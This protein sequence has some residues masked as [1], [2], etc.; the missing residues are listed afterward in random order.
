MVDKFDVSSQFSS[1]AFGVV[2]LISSAA[3]GIIAHMKV[4]SMNRLII[5]P[6]LLAVVA[7]AVIP[8][9]NNVFLYIAL[10]AVATTAGY[11][12]GAG[13]TVLENNEVDAARATALSFMGSVRSLF[14]I[15]GPLIFGGIIDSIDFTNM[16]YLSSVACAASLVI[17]AF[18]IFFSKKEKKD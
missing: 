13:I 17:L 6:T 12:R 8:S 11:F 7:Y 18:A 5:V 3:A 10:I 9:V 16:F 14:W 4:P 2:S 15:I 1:I